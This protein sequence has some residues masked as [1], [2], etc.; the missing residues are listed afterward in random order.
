MRHLKKKYQTPIRPWDK[1]RLDS[2]REI[3]NSFGLKNK[4]ELWRTQASLRKYRQIARGLQA[5]S[6]KEKERLIIEKLVKMGILKDGS[7]LDDILSLKTQDF[8]ERRLQTV[9]QRKGAANTIGHARQMIVHGHVKVGDRKI[10]Y[11]SFVVSRGDEARIKVSLINPTKI[12]KKA[13]AKK[14]ESDA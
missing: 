5:R 7:G 13:E 3:L 2:E 8:L 10:S 12:V 11:P 4:R 14:V 9:L 6:D 1:Q